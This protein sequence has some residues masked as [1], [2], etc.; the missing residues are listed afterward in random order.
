MSERFSEDEKLLKECIIDLMSDIM[1]QFWKRKSDQITEKIKLSEMYKDYE[2][3]A[4]L[5][6][7]KELVTGNMIKIIGLQ[8][9]KK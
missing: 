3:I 2:L 1:K 6:L 7:E 4:D 9:L 8:E 5:Q